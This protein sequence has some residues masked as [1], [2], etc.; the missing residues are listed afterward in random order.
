LTPSRCD[1][2][3][4]S[5]L[6]PAEDSVAQTRPSTPTKCCLFF[7]LRGLGEDSSPTELEASSAGAGARSQLK[8]SSAGAEDA[9]Q[10]KAIGFGGR[11]SPGKKKARQSFAS[12]LFRPWR[13]SK[14]ATEPCSDHSSL[15]NQ[16]QSYMQ[17]QSHIQLQ[18]SK[19]AASSSFAGAV[20]A[21]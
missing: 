14:L 6:L 21:N 13:K 16:A 12:T 9:T 4:E 17:L 2:R 11:A 10:H 18:G 19:A 8:R 7:G 5:R 20:G 3:Q 1:A 15:Q